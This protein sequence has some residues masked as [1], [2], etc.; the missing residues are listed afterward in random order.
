MNCNKYDECNDKDKCRP[1]IVYY[2]VNQNTD[3]NGL[4]AFGG[5]FSDETNVINI[6][7][8]R[9]NIIPLSSTM[10]NLNT[11]YT[12]NSITINQNGIYEINYFM[13]VSVEVATL[14]T[15]AVRRNGVEIPSTIIRRLVEVD[16][17]TVYS[18]ST[19][20]ELSQGDVIDMSL[21]ALIALGITLG[22]G[23]N[24]TLTVKKLN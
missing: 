4:R 14:L 17:G 16:T 15:L 12:D 11:T 13:N 24:A 23:V 3:H 18:G 9:D 5:R 2:L 21:S 6:E 20:V 22:D 19:I 7:V 8:G 10:S 1:K